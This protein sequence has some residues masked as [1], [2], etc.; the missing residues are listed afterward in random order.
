MYVIAAGLGCIYVVLY[1]LSRKEM[2]ANVPSRL[3]SSFYRMASYLYKRLCFEKRS[4]FRSRQADQDLERLYPG[5]DREKLRTAYY[6]KKLALSLA[7]CFVGTLLGALL[8]VKAGM[9]GVLTE[10]G[11][12]L[13]GT[14]EDGDRE[15]AVKTSLDKVG[16]QVFQ[17]VVSPQSLSGQELLKLKQAFGER[18]PQL[19][20]GENESLRQVSG[21]LCLEESFDNFPFDIEWKSNRPDLVSAWG[22]VRMTEETGEEVLLT[23]VVSYEDLQ[24]EERIAVYVVPPAISNEESIRQELEKLILK[25]EQDSRQKEEWKLPSTFYEQKLSWQQAV[26]DNSLLMWILTIAVAAAVYLFSDKDLHSLLLERRANMKKDY[27]DVVHKLALYLGA[28][29]TIRGTFQRM[30]MEAEKSK[31]ADSKTVVK[32]SK[33]FDSRIAVRTSTTVASAPIYQEILYTCRELG[34]G[35]SEGT[36]YEHFG[37]RTGL[38]E[39]IRLSTL[40]TQ[41]LKKGNAALLSRLRE[42]AQGAASE[43]LQRS[44]R[45]SE[46]AGTKLLLPMIMMLVVVMLIIMIPAFS[47]MGL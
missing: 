23:A 4:L 16:E 11:T 9:S 20:L 18:L 40:L 26:E 42:E 17:V 45:M 46:E 32:E 2:P 19:I 12:I 43:R 33:K 36:A 29:M 35:V 15:I 7:I 31:E 24:W 21:N 8:G 41:N 1:I 34:S 6:V 28:G 13:R 14:Y 27:P 22:T 10:E 3:M 30:S 47:S 44:R 37:K 5:E 38:Q 25:S 39:Y